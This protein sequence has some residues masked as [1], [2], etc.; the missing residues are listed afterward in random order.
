MY[1]ISRLLWIFTRPHI[2]IETED[3]GPDLQSCDDLTCTPLSD[4]LP[5]TATAADETH[6]DG[7]PQ[8]LP[9]IKTSQSQENV[10]QPAQ[11]APPTRR[12][13]QP[14]REASKYNKLRLK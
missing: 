4:S 1:R 6:K 11:P 2:N 8:V 5:S 12:L 10:Q 3:I 7:T 13:P 14:P 9:R